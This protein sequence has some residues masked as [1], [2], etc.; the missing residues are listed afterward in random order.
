MK[1]PAFGKSLWDRRMMG[2]SIRVICLLVGN[3]WKLPKGFAIPPEVPKLAVKTASWHLPTAERYDWRVV[4]SRP[5]CIA[6]TVL[7]VDTRGPDEREAGPDDWDPWLWLLSDVQRYARDVLRFTI[8]EEFHDQRTHFAAERDLAC[9]AW[10]CGE[11]KEGVRGWPPW[12]PYGDLIDKDRA[13]PM[14]AAA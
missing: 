10:L 5:R 1:L 14:E 6:P 3:T 12:W 2:E 9:F 8:T 11:W 7:A 4:G 13:S